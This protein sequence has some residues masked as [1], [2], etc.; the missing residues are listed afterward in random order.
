M[1]KPLVRRFLA[2]CILLLILSPSCSNAADL[3]PYPNELTG[4]KFYSQFMAPLQPD[5][6]DYA[7]VAK[8]LGS[9]AEIQV[10]DWRICPYYFENVPGTPGTLAFIEVTPKHRVL[11]SRSSLSKEFKHSVGTASEINLLFDVYTDSFGLEYWIYKED[12]ST[13]K[14]GDLWKIKYGPSQGIEAG[15]PPKSER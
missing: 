7:L 13:A 1:R 2:F 11:I 14:K 9:N 5:V 8:I 6:S 15:G 4:Y 12:S 10:G 3:N